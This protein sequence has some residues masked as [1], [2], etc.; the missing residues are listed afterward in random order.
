MSTSSHLS[1][2]EVAAA[3]CNEGTVSSK[4]MYHGYTILKLTIFLLQL[5]SGAVCIVGRNIHDLGSRVGVHGGSDS[6]SFG[7]AVLLRQWMFFYMK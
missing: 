5:L 4:I 6:G 3:K 1:M 7:L 2:E